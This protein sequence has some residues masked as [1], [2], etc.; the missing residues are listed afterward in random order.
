V[1]TKAKATEECTTVF[2]IEVQKETIDKAFDEVYAEITKV[3]NIPGFRAGKAPKELVKKHYAGD[4]KSEVL[5]RLI[6][7]AYADALREHNINPIGLPEISEVKFENEDILS[8]KAKVDTRPKFKLKNYKGIKIEKKK[9]VVKDE[10]VEKVLQNLREMSAKYITVEDRP[11]QMGDCVVSDLE[12]S[13]E[14]KPVHKKRENLWLYV[15]K[16]SVVPGL[17]EKI[18]GMNKG[19]E[20]DVEVALP[21]KYPDKNLAGKPAVYRIK[22][23]EIKLRQLPN[24]DDEFAKELGKESFEDLKKE[25]TAELEARA[26]ASADIDVE[27][28]LLGKLADENTFAVPSSFVARQ[29]DFMIEDAKRHLLEKGFKK[30]DLDKKDN[31]FKEKFKNDAVRKV[32]LLFI[33]DQIA[34]DENID[35]TDE[36]LGEAYKSISAQ[37]GKSEEEVKDYYDREDMVDSLKDRLREGKTMEFLLQN[38]QIV[39]V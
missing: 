35:V 24:L 31:E 19:E 23:K 26:K 25:V 29:L 20:K 15:E 16:D 33:L 22:A 8:F 27:N 28:Q 14:G 37:S 17:S 13:V 4:A 38:A 6:P 9:A 3:A 5:K 7:Q 10:E 39:E 34:R 11:V 36:E 30:E 1:K 21:E 12:C 18:V 32:R 2:E